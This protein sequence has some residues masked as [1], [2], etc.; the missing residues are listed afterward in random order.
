MLL[1]DINPVYPDVPSKLPLVVNTLSSP[2]TTHY[3]SVT[4][5]ALVLSKCIQ[6]KGLSLS[7]KDTDG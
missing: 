5:L 4:N 2:R 3:I 1:D 7:V 6:V